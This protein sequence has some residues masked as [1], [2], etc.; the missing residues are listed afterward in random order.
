[1]LPTAQP[2][3]FPDTSE[4]LFEGRPPLAKPVLP[5]VQGNGRYDNLAGIPFC[6]NSDRSHPPAGDSTF[7]MHDCIKSAGQL[8]V[9][10]LGAQ[11]GQRTQ[12]NQP[13]RYRRSRVRMDGSAASG[14]PCVQRSQEFADLGTAALPHD[15]SIRP[16]AQCLADQL[17]EVEGTASFQIAVPRFQGDYVGMDRVQFGGVF[18]EHKPL[19]GT[20]KAQHRRQERSFTRPGGSANE[21][22]KVPFHDGFQHVLDHSGKHASLAELIHGEYFFPSDPDG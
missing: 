10:S 8:E 6:Q 12:G 11:T 9:Y 16:H 5:S 20:A 1:M 19:F 13:C 15:Q 7:H 4:P 17:A 2:T 22:A 14:V 18:D 21:E 3:I